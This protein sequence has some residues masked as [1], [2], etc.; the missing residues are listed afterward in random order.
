M[1]PHI[2][3]VIFPSMNEELYRRALEFIPASWPHIVKDGNP[4]RHFDEL[5]GLDI[6][7]RWALNIDEDAF[8]IDPAAVLELIR[9]MEREGYDTAGIQDGSSHLRQHN[10]TIFNPFFFVFNV[11]KLQASTKSCVDPAAES[12]RYAHLVRFNN[13]PAQFDNFEP[14]YPFFVDLLH[15]GLRPLYL[16]N[17]EFSEFPADGTNLGKPSVVMDDAGRELCVHS[18]Y[19]R[20]YHEPIVRQRIQHCV[21]HAL[22]SPF[23]SHPSK[24]VPPVTVLIPA[25]NAEAT[26]AETLDSLAAQTFQQF[27]VLLIDDASSDGTA[28]LAARYADRLRMDVVTLAENAG[29]AGAINQGL[30][31]N[32]SPYIARIDADDV[33]LP[34]RLEKQL[35][36]LEARPDIDVCSTWM[37]LFSADPGYAGGVTHKPLEDADIKTSLV[38]YCA[39]SH[40]ASMFRQSFFT[41]VGV[42][43]TRLDYAEDYDL[44]CRGALLGKRY[45][46]L[47]EPLTRYRQHANQVGQQK[48]QLQYER[49]L[50][51]KQKY[52]SALLGST[53][54]GH[55]PEFLHLLTR[56][57]SKEIATRV[58][59]DSMPVM[60]QLAQRL[61]NPALFWA[62]VAGSVDRHLM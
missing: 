33:A 44:W 48:R 36:F 6:K 39:V 56:F 23:S 1:D 8:L 50:K 53:A 12:Q 49:D 35:R 7:T 47:P 21:D 16:P 3:T 38:Q 41:D 42:F 5:R 22:R 55:L 24:T 43:D 17:R 62:I 32:T 27:S 45:A 60:S 29:V 57:S 58:L 59:R 31:R 51:I 20:L 46:N 37:E 30:A 61:P 40:G 10:P 13:G 25:H 14:Y 26:L 54:I 34:T 2:P 4:T 19:S 28:A 9:R 15:C 18:W 52:L 11:E